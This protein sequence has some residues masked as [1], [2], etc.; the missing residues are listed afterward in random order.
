MYDGVIKGIRAIIGVCIYI[1]SIFSTDGYYIY[2]TL[3]AIDPAQLNPIV[4]KLPDPR[5]ASFE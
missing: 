5:G 1:Y 2:I 3:I 4:N